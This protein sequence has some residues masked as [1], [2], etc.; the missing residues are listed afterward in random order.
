MRNHLSEQ[1]NNIEWR[2][3]MLSTVDRREIME[4]LFFLEIHWSSRTTEQTTSLFVLTFYAKSKF[5][6]L[7][8]L[9]KISKIRNKG[10]KRSPFHSTSA[11]QGISS[12][13]YN[14]YTEIV[15]VEKTICTCFPSTIKASLYW[16]L[17]KCIEHC[18]IQGKRWWLILIYIV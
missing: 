13:S 3:L 14:K 4:I 18:E 8:I 15:V 6:N 2:T 12:K 5:K 16:Y 9:G 17:V 1:G 11:W 7:D 10:I